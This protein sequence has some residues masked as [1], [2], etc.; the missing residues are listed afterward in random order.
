MP[1]GAAP[2]AAARPCGGRARGGCGGSWTCCTCA[3]GSAATACAPGSP[4]ADGSGAGQ[5]EQASEQAIEI[6]ASRQQRPEVRLRGL[7]AAVWLR[8]P[9][10]RRIPERIRERSRRGAAEKL[11][12][13]R[14]RALRKAVVTG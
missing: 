12:S 14:L 13:P 5:R 4:R 3:T 8:V 7:A 6:A 9:K 11:G 1:P 2:P 10:K